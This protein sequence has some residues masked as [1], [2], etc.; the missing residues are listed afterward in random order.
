M[1]N[2]ILMSLLAVSMIFATGCGSQMAPT[3]PMTPSAVE[4]PICP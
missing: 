3:G 2:L 4:E 1:K